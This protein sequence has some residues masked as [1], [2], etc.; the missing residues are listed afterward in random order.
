MQEKHSIIYDVL[1]MVGYIMFQYS[2]WLKT[3]HSIYPHT[4]ENKTKMILFEPKQFP[5]NS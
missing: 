3:L 1:S 5:C 2:S 4:K